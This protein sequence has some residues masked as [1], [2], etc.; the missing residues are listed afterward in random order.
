MCRLPRGGMEA[1]RLCG[2][3]LMNAL[4]QALARQWEWLWRRASLGRGASSGTIEHGEHG[5]RREARR[6]FWVEFR[7]GQRQ[8]E[9]TCLEAPVIRRDP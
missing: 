7:E 9:K 5:D 4:R 1:S 6:R 2:N 8:A 3:E